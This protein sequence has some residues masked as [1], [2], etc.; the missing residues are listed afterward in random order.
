MDAFVSLYSTIDVPALF[1]AVSA[2][3][4]V[5]LLR[6]HRTALVAA[7]SADDTAD[8]DLLGLYH[9]LR[10]LNKMHDAFNEHDRLVI[11]FATWFEPYVRRW[12]AATEQKT[13]EWV[14][15][16]IAHDKVSF[17]SPPPPVR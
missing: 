5:Q 14:R 2:R 13:S 8:D 15:N 3:A 16:A 7:A 4:Y 10:E 1:L 11:D 6:Q 9:D 12:L 17:R